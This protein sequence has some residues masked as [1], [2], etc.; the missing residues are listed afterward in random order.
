MDLF[1]TSRRAG[2]ASFAAGPI[3]PSALAHAIARSTFEFRNC[4]INSGTNNT[5]CKTRRFHV[6]AAEDLDKLRQ[7]DGRIFPNLC[8]E[9]QTRV[10]YSTA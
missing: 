7:C 3:W 2:N 6:R 4:L 8:S 5:G 10:V 9:V 1:A